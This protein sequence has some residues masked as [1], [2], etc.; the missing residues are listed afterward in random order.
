MAPSGL[1]LR[2]HLVTLTGMLEFAAAAGL[3]L[4][5]IAPLAGAGLVLLLIAMFPANVK[6]AVE[7]LPL[8]GKPATP[9]LLRLPL[10]ALF[11][12]ATWWASQPTRLLPGS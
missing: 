11:I 9:M 7:N 8:R 6:A 3:A 1:P 5:A 12:A 10:Q 4:P 2:A